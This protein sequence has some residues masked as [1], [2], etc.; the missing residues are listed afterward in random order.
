MNCHY[1]S[2]YKRCPI[3]TLFI[4]RVFNANGSD[5]LKQTNVHIQ[6]VHDFKGILIVFQQRYFFY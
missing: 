4:Y 5:F 2:F 3:V 1:R 6:I